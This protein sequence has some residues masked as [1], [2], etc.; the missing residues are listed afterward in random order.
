MNLND[1]LT[2]KGID[3]KK[4]IVMRHRPWE[5]KLNR[6]MPWLAAK[7]P[8]LFN[9]Y[10]QT[11]GPIVEKALQ[12]VNYLASFIGRKPGKALFVGLFKMNGS[13]EMTYEA[14]VQLPLS[15]ELKS[16]GMGGAKP[17]EEPASI[18]W[19]DLVLD[20]AFYPE[21]KGRLV[22]KWPT[23]DRSWWR[24]AHKNEM[25]I[26]AI[27]ENSVLEDAMPAWN[28]L[29]LTWE[30]LKIMPTRW[31]SEIKR[32]R[33][34]YYI[35]DESDG[36]GYVGS[37]YGIE[38]IYG[39]WTSAYAVTGHGGNKLLK[40]RDP[41]NFHF[42][43]LQLVAHDTESVDVIRLEKTWKDRLHTRSPFGLNDN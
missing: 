6:V 35:F 41:V 42:S 2:A 38:N 29:L 12:K 43:V 34:I 32:W 11:Q 7:R 24:R 19:F 18:R 37:A 13:T 23:P 30:Q 21:W 17:G 9:A 28:A 31:E 16:L 1:L 3:L 36:K 22:V 33:G 14:C 8:E 27:H 5:Q 26:L 40:G 20:E 39:R 25:P 4:V 15:L 10:Q